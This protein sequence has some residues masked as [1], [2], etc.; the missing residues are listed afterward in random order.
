MRD[1]EFIGLSDVQRDI[2]NW[3]IKILWGL[4]LDVKGEVGWYVV[5]GSGGG[6]GITMGE[7]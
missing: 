4:S 5:V 1:N 7:V 6:G 3:D 2:I